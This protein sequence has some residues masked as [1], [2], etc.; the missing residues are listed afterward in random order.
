MR[1]LNAKV[2]QANIYW[3]EVMRRHGYSRKR[4]VSLRFVFEI[5]VSDWRH[6]ISSHQNVEKVTWVSPDGSTTKTKRPFHH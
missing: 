3:G 5:R 4:R 6:T 1:N 2:S